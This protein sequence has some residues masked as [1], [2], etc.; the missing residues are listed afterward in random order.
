MS[1]SPRKEKGNQTT[2]LLRWLKCNINPDVLSFSA[3][4]VAFSHATTGQIMKRCGIDSWGGCTEGHIAWRSEST[5]VCPRRE[6]RVGLTVGSP[7]SGAV[8]AVGCW[9]LLGLRTWCW[10]YVCICHTCCTCSEQHSL[11][12]DGK[13]SKSWNIIHFKQPGGFH[14]ASGAIWL[15]FSKPQ[16]LGSRDLRRCYSSVTYSHTGTG[17]LQYF[18][19]SEQKLEMSWIYKAWNILRLLLKTMETEIVFITVEPDSQYLQT[20]VAA[21]CWELRSTK[22]GTCSIV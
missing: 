10:K 12:K 18:T 20:P 13:I 17:A 16:L 5:C 2:A 7:C 21:C 3:L 6:R 15:F 4:W 1:L 8:V 22:Y 9:S 14:P 19:L 11:L